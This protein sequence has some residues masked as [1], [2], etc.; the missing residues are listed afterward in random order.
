MDSVNKM[1]TN[2]VRSRWPSAIDDLSSISSSERTGAKAPPCRK[3]SGKSGSETKKRKCTG[4]QPTSKLFRMTGKDVSQI[5]GIDA[6][7][8]MTILGEAGL[9]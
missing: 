1:V 9:P 7:T 8:A 5:D 2:S 6:M 4:I 3:R